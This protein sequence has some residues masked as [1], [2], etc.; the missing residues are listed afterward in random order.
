MLLS[1][2]KVR[3]NRTWHQ[4]HHTNCQKEFEKLKNSSYSF[5]LGVYS[6]SFSYQWRFWLFRDVI[7]IIM[8]CYLHGYPWPSLTTPPY[9]SS[10]PASLQNY[11]PYPHIAAVCMFELVVLLLLGHMWGSIGV[12][13][14]WARLCFSSSVLF[15]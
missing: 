4:Y 11:I 10:S 8:L 3:A 9:R 1:K 12:H 2:G 14:L 15:V 5:I 6:Q 13:H 7:I